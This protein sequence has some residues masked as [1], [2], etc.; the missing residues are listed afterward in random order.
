VLLE[1]QEGPV[2]PGSNTGRGARQQSR[3]A[4]LR[5]DWSG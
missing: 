4:P 1:D 2:D 5:P 3:S